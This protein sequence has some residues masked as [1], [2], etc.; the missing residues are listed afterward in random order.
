MVSDVALTTGDESASSEV[1][2]RR[3]RPHEARDVAALLYESA[4]AKYDQFAGSRAGALPLLARAFRKGGNTASQETVSVAEVDGQVAGVLAAFP[5]REGDR[6]ASR[7]FRT[8]LL[9]LPPWRWPEALRIFRLGTDVTPPPP[10]DALYVDALATGVGFR[11]RGVARALLVDAD[12]RA[13]EAGL[14]A[15]A[16]DTG[17]ANAS[18]RALY[19][20][21]GFRTTAE[22]RPHGAMPGVAAYV[23]PVA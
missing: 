18:A 20:G 6:R 7:F 3:A 12:R 19:E 17:L 22:R 2:V 8:A 4:A 13:R 23:K 5:A 16:L 11:R 15:V 21:A 1:T 10:L 14:A 9:A